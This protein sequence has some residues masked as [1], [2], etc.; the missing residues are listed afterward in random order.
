MRPSAASARARCGARPP[1]AAARA[2]RPISISAA[3]GP[4]PP[5][6]R[7]FPLGFER[8]HRVRRRRGQR[9]R[10]PPYLPVHH[11]RPLRRHPRARVVA[12]G[13]LGPPRPPRRVPSAPRARRRAQQRKRRDHARGVS[14]PFGAADAAPPPPAV[15]PGGCCRSREGPLGPPPLTRPPPA[16]DFAAVFSTSRSSFSIEFAI[17][18]IGKTEI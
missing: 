11:R 16:L 12:P 13:V 9:H 10:S 4:S 15:V 7:E 6:S 14:P 1:G 2:A 17:K 3:S 5:P 8:A 18:M